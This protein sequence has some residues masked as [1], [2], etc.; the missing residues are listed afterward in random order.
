M[1]VVPKQRALFDVSTSKSGP[2]MVCFFA[3]RA[4]YFLSLI[5]PAGSAPAALASLLFDPPE[6]QI[7]GKTTVNP[8]FATFFAHLHLLSSDPLSSLIFSCFLLLSD[9]SHLCLPSVHMV[10]SLASK[11]PSISKGYSHVQVERKTDTQTR[12]SDGIGK[13]QISEIQD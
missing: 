13:R 6:P 8:D 5:W 2:T 9:S 4:Y 10:R 12:N 11:L 1:C 3:A 7:T